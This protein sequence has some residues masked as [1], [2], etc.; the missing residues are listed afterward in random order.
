VSVRPFE[1][2]VIQLKKNYYRVQ[3]DASLLKTPC[4]IDVIDSISEVHQASIQL[5]DSRDQQ[6]NP[7]KTEAGRL[8]LQ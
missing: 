2:P 3:D 7:D 4:L 5:I 1:E 8:S 6:L